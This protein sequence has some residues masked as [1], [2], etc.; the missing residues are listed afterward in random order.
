MRSIGKKGE[1]WLWILI[2]LAVIGL[3]FYFAILKGEQWKPISEHREPA[4]LSEDEQGTGMRL[5]LYDKDGNPIGIPDWFK[6]TSSVTGI[7][8]AIVAHPGAGERTCSVLNDCYDPCVSDADCPT[9]VKCSSDGYC[10]KDQWT[11]IMCYDYDVD[12][13]KECI[14]G[15]IGTI[16]L[17]FA[18]S[19]GEYNYQNVEVTSAQPSVYYSALPTDS[20]SISAGESEIF[21]SD[22]LKV[23]TDAVCPSGETCLD[24][25]NLVGAG[26]TTFSVSV[27]GYNLFTQQTDTAGDS[28]VLQFTKEPTA[29]LSVSIIS[30]I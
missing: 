20:R 5:R 14:L 1:S 11:Q 12:N 21:Q 13:T 30:P 19:A 3:I 22:L 23:D 15:S 24:A 2:I 17:D 4:D 16:A 25:T 29:G 8:G 27:S 9:G 10:G 18:V 28:I 7:T 26:P 6:V